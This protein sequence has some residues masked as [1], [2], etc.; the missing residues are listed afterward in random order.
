MDAKPMEGFEPTNPIELTEMVDIERVQHFEHTVSIPRSRGGYVITINATTDVEVA[1]AEA[2]EAARRLGLT[3][4]HT[5]ERDHYHK[6]VDYEGRYGMRYKDSGSD[7]LDGREVVPHTQ[8]FIRG[9]AMRGAR[10]AYK[11]VEV[12]E[13]DPIPP[14]EFWNLEF[15]CYPGGE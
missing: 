12:Y 6:M 14:S 4:L 3:V 9:E 1:T 10:D 13:L 11:G 15:H 5:I 8:E 2:H 7:Y